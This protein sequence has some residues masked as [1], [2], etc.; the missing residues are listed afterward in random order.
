MTELRAAWAGVRKPAAESDVSLLQNVQTGSEAKA[1]SYSMG[2]GV[3]F[4]AS[5]VE[6]CNDR[7]P[8]FSAETT[9]KKSYT[10]AERNH[11]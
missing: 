9:N 6:R 1:A 10:E 4:W 2:N 5:E 7:L 8:P 11:Y 3:S